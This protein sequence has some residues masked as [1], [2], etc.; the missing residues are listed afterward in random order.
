MKFLSK[1]ADSQILLQKLIYKKNTDNSELRKFL[2][3][4]Q[5]NFCAYTEKYVE[6]L[7]SVEIEHFNSSLKHKDNYYNYYAVVRWANQI[8]KDEKYKNAPFFDTLFFQNE[9][10][11][12]IKFIPTDLV[13]EEIN[14]D[15]IEAIDFIDFIGLNENDLFKDRKSHINPLKDFFIPE[16][17]IIGY[18]RKHKQELKFITAIEVEFNIDLSEFYS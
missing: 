5:K 4:E 9:F 18:F 8:K 3:K 13:Y 16:F 17:D 12:R 14:P 2:L 7:D 1:R 10:A 15:D 11:A 6:G